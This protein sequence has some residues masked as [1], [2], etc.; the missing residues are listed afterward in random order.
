MLKFIK[1]LN[2]LLAIALLISFGFVLGK[3]YDV[4]IDSNYNISIVKQSAN[5]KKIRKLF[6]LIDQQY[7]E[8]VNSDSLMDATLNYVLQGLDPHSTYLNA[9]ERTAQADIS[10]EFTDLGIDYFIDKDTITVIRTLE[11]SP[12]RNALLPGDKLLTVNN[13]MI[14]GVHSSQFNRLIQEGKYFTIKVKRNHQTKK[15]EA[16]KKP[17][18]VDNVPSAYLIQS[19]IGYIRLAHFANNTAKEFHD[20]LRRLLNLGA[21][22]IILD[23]RD[24]GGGLLK[25]AEKIADEFLAKDQMILY[26][27]NMKDKSKKYYYASGGGLYEKGKLV[28]LIN[29][30]SASA[31]EVLAGALQDNDR[32]IIVGRRSFGKGLVQKEISMEDGST[33]RITTAQYFTPSG[34]KIQKNYEDEESYEGEL[35]NRYYSGEM[36]DE[37]KI[38]K[39]DSLNTKSTKGKTIYGGG[40]I[41]PEVYVA[42]KQFYF[43]KNFYQKEGGVIIRN[44]IV[45]DIGENS[46]EY[47]NLN[48][49]EF[50]S[51][52]NGER[53]YSKVFTELKNK[54]VEVSQE[55]KKLLKTYIKA[56]IGK[57]IY[58]EDA[59]YK[60]WNPEDEM[61]QK[62][63]EQTH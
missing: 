40:G 22:S 19:D 24:N 2:I 62:S 38:Q 4:I 15:V 18:P 28:V 20:N 7:I 58:G 21:K 50:I 57:I 46:A 37:S 6:N 25:E 29:E 35:M 45:K 33:F 14:T 61:I 23:V 1:I 12:N 30:H 53:L 52:F 60:I 3:Y 51:G 5:Q 13:R 59:Y 54:G 34:R 8:E 32:A 27:Q 47:Y 56:Y 10:G 16:E 31:S 48:Q 26:L 11:G 41:V 9:S 42:L 63:I 36:Y 39:V 49:V 43:G 17:F 55:G 44:R